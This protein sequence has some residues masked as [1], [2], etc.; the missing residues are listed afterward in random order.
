MSSPQASSKSGTSAFSPTA[1]AESIEALQRSVTCSR[2]AGPVDPSPAQ[3]DRTQ[4][5]LLQ[6]R[7]AL[8]ARI[9][10]QR[11]SDSRRS[12][13]Q[14]DGF[15][16]M[17]YHRST[18]QRLLR[19]HSFE[20]RWMCVRISEVP[21]FKQTRSGLNRLCCPSLG[22]SEPFCTLPNLHPPPRKADQSP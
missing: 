17:A 11:L 10:S 7:N 4:M 5:P 19:L 9:H 18:N 2:T 8:P 22:R 15:L 13:F 21:V 12:G 3:C 14:L 20:W 6:Y 1:T 16:V